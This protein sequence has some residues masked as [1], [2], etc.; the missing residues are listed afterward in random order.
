MLNHPGKKFYLTRNYRCD[1]SIEQFSNYFQY[2]Q[3]SVGL[4]DYKEEYKEDQLSN[5]S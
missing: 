4:E 2:Y 3:H 1:P 5:G